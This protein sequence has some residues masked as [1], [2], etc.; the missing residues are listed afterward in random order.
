MTIKEHDLAAMSTT[1]ASGEGEGKGEC[2][3]QTL[4][5]GQEGFQE[6]STFSD[7]LYGCPR[8]RA[9]I[10]H[11]ENEKKCYSLCYMQSVI[12]FASTGRAMATHTRIAIFIWSSPCNNKD[13]TIFFLIWNEFYLEDCTSL[14]II[15]SEDDICTIAHSIFLC[16]LSNSFWLLIAAHS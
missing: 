15:S 6:F 7:A 16:S 4:A 11:P 10:V 5:D 8:Y 13:R 12:L 2:A 14:G 1:E 9:L 3:I